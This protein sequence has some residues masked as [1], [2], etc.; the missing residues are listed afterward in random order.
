MLKNVRK[1]EVE[2]LVFM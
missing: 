1:E 2:I